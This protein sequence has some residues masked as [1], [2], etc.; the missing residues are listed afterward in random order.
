MLIML[1]GFKHLLS[2]DY[3]DKIINIIM[4]FIFWLTNKFDT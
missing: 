3:V 2:E 1:G 4:L